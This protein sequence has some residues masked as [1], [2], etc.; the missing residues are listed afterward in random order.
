MGAGGGGLGEA[1]PSLEDALLFLSTSLLTVSS[2]LVMERERCLLLR[3][4]L[5][6]EDEPGVTRGGP[7]ENS[8]SRKAVGSII[9]W[10]LLALFTSLAAAATA[11]ELLASSDAASSCCCSNILCSCCF[12]F[13]LELLARCL[14]FTEELLERCELLLVTVAGE[15]LLGT[16]ALDVV[17]PFSSWHCCAKLS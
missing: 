4:L 6:D 17:M 15:L 12:S 7:S 10:D 5:D 2:S 11:A 14:W 8:V 9:S 3:L 13:S 16:E 1:E